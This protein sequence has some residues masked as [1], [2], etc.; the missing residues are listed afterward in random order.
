MVKVIEIVLALGF[1]VNSY[2]A[3]SNF[4]MGKSAQRLFNQADRDL[5]E[6]N[7]IHDAANAIWLKAQE[8]PTDQRHIVCSEC[9]RIVARHDG[10]ICVNCAATLAKAN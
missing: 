4:L 9:N 7:K 2:W 1:V 6:A 3:Y 5:A 10:K 8:S